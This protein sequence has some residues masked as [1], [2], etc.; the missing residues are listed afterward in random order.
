MEAGCGVARAEGR[1]QQRRESGRLHTHSQIL[2]AQ[3]PRPPLPLGAVDAR[4][5]D[6]GEFDSERYR[7]LYLGDY[8]PQ[9]AAARRS[10]G[11]GGGWED[12]EFVQVGGG[13]R[14]SCRVL[15]RKALGA[16]LATDAT[17][18]GP[19]A[20]V[21]PPCS[22]PNCTCAAA[23]CPSAS[24]SSLPGSWQPVLCPSASPRFVFWRSRLSWPPSPPPSPCAGAPP[25]LLCR[26]RV[27]GRAHHDQPRH[28]G[29]GR[30][31]PRR[32]G[33]GRFVLLRQVGHNVLEYSQ[34][35]RWSEGRKHGEEGEV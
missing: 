27:R 30:R 9:G 11:Q 1:G 12:S 17:T 13:R 20:P 35:G 34:M 10:A 32:V 15:C 22:L 18:H 14:R 21:S 28:R 31:R 4:A 8:A 7:H 6:E 16:Q 19:F 3:R 2:A 33:G 25:G 29:P 23:V 5:A 26:L 24:P